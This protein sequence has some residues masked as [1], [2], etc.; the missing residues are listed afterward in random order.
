[1]PPVLSTPST[2][3]QAHEGPSAPAKVNILIALIPYISALPTDTDDLTYS[4]PPTTYNDRQINIM[5]HC[6]KNAD[7]LI[8]AEVP[9]GTLSIAAAL[10]SA[11][12]AHCSSLAIELPSSPPGLPGPQTTWVFLEPSAYQTI[13]GTPVRQF[14]PLERIPSH[15]LSFSS[16][17]CK[18]KGIPASANIAV[19]NH[20]GP[21]D[22]NFVFLAAP[23][24]GNLCGPLQYTRS[25]G[26]WID[27][28]PRDVST[29]VPQP[30]KSHECF[31][32][33]I[34]APVVGERLLQ[35][36]LKCGQNCPTAINQDQDDSDVELVSY[37]PELDDDDDDMPWHHLILLSRSLSSVLIS[38]LKEQTI[39]LFAAPD[40]NQ[41]R[42]GP[43]VGNPPH[44]AHAFKQNWPPLPRTW[45]SHLYTPRC[46]STIEPDRAFDMWCSEMRRRILPNPCLEFK[47]KAPNVDV[48]ARALIWSVQYSL[49]GRGVEGKL[50]YNAALSA[51]FPDLPTRGRGV[52]RGPEALI[53]SK[54]FEM[55]SGES[56]FWETRGQYRS[57][58]FDISTEPNDDRRLVFQTAGYLALAHLY[59]LKS[60]PEGL[61]PFLI[62]LAGDGHL[63]F[64][65]DRQHIGALDPS[66]D[67]VVQTWEQ[68]KATRARIELQS[69]LACYLLEV[70]GVDIDELNAGVTPERL[71]VLERAIF[72]R[73]I[74]GRVDPASHPDFV[75]FAIGFNQSFGL[76]G[77]GVIDMCGRKSFK[78]LLQVVTTCRIVG[79]DC[80][81]GR[82]FKTD[83]T[84]RVQKVNTRTED[85]LMEAQFQELLRYYLTGVGHPSDD[86]ARSLV[87]DQAFMN[88][89][90]TSPS[91][92][93]HLFMGTVR[94]VA[95]LPMGNWEIQIMFDHR[96]MAD[97]SKNFPVDSQPQAIRYHQCFM[98]FDVIVDDALRNVMRQ[99]IP[100][101]RDE[102]TAPLIFELWMHSMLLLKYI[103]NDSY[104]L[105]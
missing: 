93:A 27:H 28:L 47:L 37:L 9:S 89:E 103:E 12:R 60:L 1:M 50:R 36:Q 24:F 66:Y 88:G 100:V 35:E 63:A 44:N 74:F 105:F 42:R 68:W 18:K 22:V 45:P 30:W 19:P 52:Q 38:S 87:G 62:Q 46:P 29:L 92:R 20:V 80:I 55:I 41:W 58:K 16:I 94:G 76:P 75:A 96:R 49:Q 56:V 48:G 13:Q 10:D 43:P 57:I 90:S 99:D 32:P 61:S 84:S 5:Q 95:M 2:P 71:L 53:I 101:M 86:H 97:R 102:G 83:R 91:L 34:W 3:A 51:A 65:C 11:I 69:T 85:A 73:I 14:V 67:K 64:S 15:T 23:R 78:E 104:E 26:V 98:T 40:Q 33:R 4:P 39:L 54:A 81:I 17:T 82:P 72:S 7:L 31:P 70:D 79:P 59:C 25:D 8:P 6:L 21:H 77:G